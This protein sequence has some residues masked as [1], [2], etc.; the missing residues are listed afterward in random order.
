M[1]VA[2]FQFDVRR[3]EVE[4]NLAEVERA[5]TEARERGVD[6]VL[7]PEMW[8]T[9]FVPDG[10]E[11]DWLA[12]TEGALAHVVELSRTLGVAVAGSCLLALFAS[13]FSGPRNSVMIRSS[14]DRICPNCWSR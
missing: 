12:A 14:G 4:A 6:L 1:R 10:Q 11:G 8:P 2:A 3:G 5:L 9:S 13:R 7:L